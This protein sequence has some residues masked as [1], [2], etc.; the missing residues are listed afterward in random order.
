MALLVHVKPNGFIGSW[1]PIWKCTSN[2]SRFD[3][4]VSSL[5]G[6]P[7]I[8]LIE[9]ILLMNNIQLFT[10][11]KFTLSICKP[12]GLLLESD[13]GKFMWFK[14]SG[15]NW[16]QP[17]C[18][19]FAYPRYLEKDAQL[20]ALCTDHQDMMTRTGHDHRY[21]YTDWCMI[22]SP[23]FEN[24]IFWFVQSAQHIIAKPA[25]WDSCGLP[26]SDIWNVI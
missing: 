18:C 11:A 22:A 25:S 14:P 1:M 13:Y 10:I 2:V 12:D 17:C 5:F 23:W 26:L 3:I 4:T 6:C 19:V 8:A 7:A 21:A 24:F 15:L 20:Q 16:C 9:I